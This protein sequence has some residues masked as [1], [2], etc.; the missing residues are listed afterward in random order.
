MMLHVCC[1]Q[2]FSLVAVLAVCARCGESS[3]GDDPISRFKGYLRIDTAHP[4]AEYGAAAAF[5]LA[6][7]AEIGLEAQRLE[8]VKG[9]PVVLV[10]WVGFDASLPS[11][12][13]NSHMDVVPAEKTKWK[14]EPFSGFEVRCCEFS[15]NAACVLLRGEFFDL[16]GTLVVRVLESVDSN[17]GW[18]GQHLWEGSARHEERGDAVPGG[19]SR[20][21]DEWVSAQALCACFL[22]AR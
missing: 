15:Y 2:F 19:Y 12:L 7:A 16:H 14:H 6:Q 20:L 11:V 21:E 5:L 17:A 13:L 3:S 8:F 22:C 1:W 4:D 10:S 18:R 9:K